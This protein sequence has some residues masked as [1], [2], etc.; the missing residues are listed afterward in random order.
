M[1]LFLKLGF[2]DDNKMFSDFFK[3]KGSEQKALNDKTLQTSYEQ[4]GKRVFF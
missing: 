3:I 4:E 2:D 1:D